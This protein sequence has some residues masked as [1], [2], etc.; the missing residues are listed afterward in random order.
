MHLDKSNAISP[1]CR[2]Q[3]FAYTAIYCY[4]KDFIRSQVKTADAIQIEIEWFNFRLLR[5]V[6]SGTTRK[7]VKTYREKNKK[8]EEFIV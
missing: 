4:D 5:N 1:V 8:Y 7:N 2:R 3:V 6:Q